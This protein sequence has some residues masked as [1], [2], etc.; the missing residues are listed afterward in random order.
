MATT[1]PAPAEE[2][3]S[4]DDYRWDGDKSGI[5]YD[6]STVAPKSNCDVTFYVPSCNHVVAFDSSVPTIPSP[7]TLSACSASSRAVSVSKSFTSLLQRMSSCSIL[8]PSGGSRFTVADSGASDHM[9]PDKSAFISYKL[10]AN[11]QV[12]MGN[13]SFLPV[14]GRGSAIISLMG[15]AS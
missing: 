3:D 4:D 11:L 15:S 8:P 1:A 14:L 13:N 10:V 7:L 2:Y 12:R 5:V 9:F 6:A